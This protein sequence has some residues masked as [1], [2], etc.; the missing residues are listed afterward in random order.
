MVKLLWKQFGNPLNVNIELPDNSTIPYLS[1]YTREMKTY[2]HK[3][4]TAIFRVTFFI[5]VKE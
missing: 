4:C 3:T 5:L 1:I 2:S